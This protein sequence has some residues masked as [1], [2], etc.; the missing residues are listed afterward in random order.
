MA[1]PIETFRRF[2]ALPV[3]LVCLTFCLVVLGATVRLMGAGLSCPDWPLCNGQLIPTFE[4][5]VFFEWLHRLVAGTVSTIFMGMLAWIL[6][7]PTLRARLWKL[8]VL[9]VV[10][11][12][13]QITLGALTV[14]KMLNSN[15]VTTHLGT[16]TALFGVFILIALRSLR[17]AAGEAQ[18]VVQPKGLK[19]LALLALF[20]VYGQIL[21]GGLVASNYA[22]LACPDWPTCNGMW[23][24][25]MVGYVATHMIHRFGGYTVFCLIMALTVLGSRTQDAKTRLGVVVAC[26]LVVLQVSLGIANVLLAIPVP[27]AAAHNGV[28]ELL[29]VTMLSLNFHLFG[30]AAKADSSAQEPTLREAVA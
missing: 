28:A 11:L 15:V 13:V 24:P 2:R 19:P 9:A 23:L 26:A 14:W 12:G 27:L 16:G 18:P 29:W 22:S 3:G 1:S 5:G 6:I 17:E 25:P 20:A 4:G 21:L 10:M 30:S 8:A 7:H